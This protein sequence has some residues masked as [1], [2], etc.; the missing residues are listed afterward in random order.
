MRAIVV[1]ACVNSVAA[2]PELVKAT[3]HTSS[4]GKEHTGNEKRRKIADAIEAEVQKDSRQNFR[5]S[6][7][8]EGY[9]KEDA[10]ELRQVKADKNLG[11][12]LQVKEEPKVAQK[13]FH[14]QTSLEAVDAE[15]AAQRALSVDIHTPFAA[16]EEAEKEQYLKVKAN[17]NL[18]ALLQTRK[19]GLNDD[20]A[21][22]KSAGDAIN[23]YLREFEGAEQKN[24]DDTAADDASNQ[25]AASVKSY[26][27]DSSSSYVPRLSS[28]SVPNFE[29]TPS[30]TPSTTMPH[31]HNYG[32]NVISI[33]LS[34]QLQLGTT[35]LQMKTRIAPG[36][37]Q[38]V[39][40]E[41]R[42]DVY[43]HDDFAQQE[44][45]DEKEIRRVNSLSRPEMRP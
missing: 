4:F 11:A 31:S 45:K 1:A 25:F 13:P 28:V 44:K 23:K 24:A 30:F 41:K 34:S 21:D 15:I 16:N 2:A 20:D 7:L 17:P 26:E 22:D 9:E 36:V 37:E 8:F 32:G 5:I 40:K 19:R 39:A 10:E 3:Q 14:K 38:E 12:F 35:F 27:A 29:S 43:L 42:W 18:Q 33:P 6:G